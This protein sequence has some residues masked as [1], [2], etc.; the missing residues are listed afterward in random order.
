MGR[1]GKWEDLRGIGKGKVEMEAVDMG[2]TGKGRKRRRR[3]E[4]TSQTTTPHSETPGFVSAKRY[5]ILSA[6]TRGRSVCSRQSGLGSRTEPDG[7]LSIMSL[8]SFQ[9][10]NNPFC[11]SV[12]HEMLVSPCTS[13]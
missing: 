5:V 2:G 11:P 8:A 3:E 9:L 10:A 13:T 6:Q 1:G 7:I 12:C 4:R